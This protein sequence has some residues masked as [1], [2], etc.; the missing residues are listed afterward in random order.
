MNVFE[1]VATLNLNTTGY[2][3]GLSSAKSAL[4]GF[5]IF[6]NQA[7]A[8]IDRIAI[9]AFKSVVNAAGSFIK[10]SIDAGTEFD[11]AMSQVA[12]TMGK[13]MSEM[14]EDVKSVELSWGTFTGNLREYAQEMGR[15]T[16]FSAT[17]AAE[18][19]NYMAL[20]GY[21]VQES[22]KMLPNVL[23]LAAAG[24]MDLARA[25]DMVTDAQSAFWINSERTTQMVD[26]MAK[27]ASTGNTSVEQLG[28]A[29]LTVGGLAQELHGGLVFLGDGTH[30]AV[31][32]I[33][34][35][36]IA[37]TAM[38]NAGI[39]GSEAGTHMRNMLMKLSSPTSEGTE[40]LEKMG[41]TVFD[42]VA[43]GMRSLADIF[44]DLNYAMQSMT[45]EEKIQTISDLFNTRDLASAEALLNAIGDE[46]GSMWND[47]GQSIIKASESG[48]LYRG[49]LYG[50]EEAQRKFG[51]AIY[52]SEKGFKILGSA[53]FMAMEQMNNLEGDTK[54][55]NSALEGVR[56]A[57][58]DAVKPALRTLVKTGTEGL[59]GLAEKLDN[60]NF[61][62]KLE[63]IGEKLGKLADRAVDF[64]L[65]DVDWDAVL[66]GIAEG[67][68]KGA[69]A[70]EWLFN[71]SEKIIPI[72][73]TVITVLGA[74]KVIQIALNLAMLANPISLIIIAIAA[75]VA[76]GIALYMNWDTVKSKAKEL[77]ENIKDKFGKIKSSIESA[78]TGPVDAAKKW[79]SDLI[80]NFKKG[81]ESMLGGAQ[82]L[83]GA[84]S[85]TASKVKSYLHFSQPDEGPLADFDTYA[86]DMMKLFAQGIRD[87]ENIVTD[88]I[89]NVFGAMSEISLTSAEANGLKAGVHMM[90]MLSQGVSQN[91]NVALEQ[92]GTSKQQADI[93]LDKILNNQKGTTNQMTSQMTASLIALTKSSAAA[94]TSVSNTLGGLS[95]ASRAW[96]V[97]MVENFRIGVNSKLSSLVNTV[98]NMAKK[99]KSYLHFSEPDVGPL[100]DFHTYAPDMMKLFAQ[101]IAEG[102]HYVTDQIDKSFDFGTR[103]T[104]S[105]TSKANATTNGDN[106]S[107]KEIVLSIDGHELARFLAPAMNSQLAFT[108]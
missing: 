1:L 79:G 82:G 55:F 70:V 65:N 16:Q 24:N 45:Q 98:N 89:N 87:N 2:T 52:D 81:I 22:M 99:I 106:I 95:K 8:T 7:F 27:A 14:S 21:D 47:I 86:P 34:E 66:D 38:A 69:D 36:E 30:V 64:L 49:Q 48:V 92:L 96:G 62:D 10:S 93:I 41:V 26:E 5:S 101:G 11:T 33:T 72:I 3:S 46:T 73:K 29:F 74:W 43:G 23:N 107:G 105:A 32:G 76:A 15:N 53:E 85:K 90:D 108:R 61:R 103:I 37:L 6:T 20:A 84:L 35:L 88:E 39:K 4:S 44:S 42:T 31:D 83:T 91:S 9:N 17:Q 54:L 51:D 97:D 58:S 40:R 75:L 59:S 104:D 94:N 25:S 80:G 56:I 68:D 60:A 57:I 50:M 77:W 12:A 100:S 78:F 71:N 19:L 28:D 63:K 67:I 18:A 13:T 102:E